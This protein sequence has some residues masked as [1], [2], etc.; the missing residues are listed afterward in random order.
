MRVCC[1]T[2]AGTAKHRWPALN[3]VL[4]ISNVPKIRGHGGLRQQ[5]LAAGCSDMQHISVEVCGQ[6]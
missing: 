2:G 3:Y 6:L 5:Y 1:V 4:T